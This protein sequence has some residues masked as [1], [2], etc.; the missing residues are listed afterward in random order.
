M[1]NARPHN[2]KVSV[3]ALKEV[4]AQRVMHPPYSPD[5]SPCD[6]FL[7]GAL[8]EKLAGMSFSSS[9]DLVSKIR[10][11]F[12]DFSKETLQLVYM[13]WSKRLKWV[14]EHGGEYYESS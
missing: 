14:I 8:K 11:I 12:S 3:Q 4:K 7:F 1:D 2:S 9:E 10:E 6:F 13:N 5:L